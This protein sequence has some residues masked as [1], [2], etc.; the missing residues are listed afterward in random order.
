M[1]GPSVTSDPDIPDVDGEDGL[2]ARLEAASA[3]ARQAGLR[4]IELRGAPDSL[5]IKEKGLQD[6]VTRADVEVETLIR[7]RLLGTFPSDGF[8]G[9]ES[10]RR[11][12]EGAAGMW[13]VDPIDG[14]SNFIR[15]IRH[16]GVS[17]AYVRDGQIEVGAVYDAPNDALYCAGRG[18][19][20]TRNNRTIAVSSTHEMTR[21]M[22]IL[23]MS[24]RM[25][26]EDYL[27]DIRRLTEAGSDYRRLGSA[28]IGLVRVAEGVAD[29]Y[30]EAHLNSWD[31]LA[32][33][34]IVREA[35]G[36]VTSVDLATMLADGGP[37][38]ASN[39]ILG[40]HVSFLS[41]NQDI[42]SQPA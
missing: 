18:K 35:G 6:F 22:A 16:W 39:G 17:I 25:D 7:D 9:E 41:S 29:F 3:V 10:E 26:A 33:M 20:A 5:E 2:S 11:E 42:A 14:T 8:L 36:F 24:Q 4:A 27:N 15:G 1:T 34:L 19:G 30:Y 31:A 28:A 32:G 37:V 12:A 13:V 21:A 40:P 23:G 38:L